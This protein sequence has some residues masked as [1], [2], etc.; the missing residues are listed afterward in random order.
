MLKICWNTATTKLLMANKRTFG[1]PSECFVKVWPRNT[2]PSIHSF[3]LNEVLQMA[4]GK[5]R[6]TVNFYFGNLLWLSLQAV[7]RLVGTG[8]WQCCWCYWWFGELVWPASAFVSRDFGERHENGI[9]DTQT[10]THILGPANLQPLGPA[11]YV[12][13]RINFGQLTDHMPGSFAQPTSRPLCFNCDPLIVVL[14][15]P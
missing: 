3:V 2:L 14:T 9:F 11:K 4:V 8:C 10:H 15:R 12:N 6:H 7:I 13:I 1:A 5:I